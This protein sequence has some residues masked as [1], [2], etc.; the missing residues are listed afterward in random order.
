MATFGQRSEDNLKTCHD[1]IQRLFRAVVLRRDCS[2]ICGHRDEAAQTL[3]YSQGNSEAQ[4]DESMHNSFPSEAG[5]LIPYPEGFGNPH[6]PAS[7]ERSQKA[8]KELA[9]IVFD[10]A[11]KLGI[12][13][14]WGG[15]FR[16]MY[17]NET[18][19]DGDKPHWELR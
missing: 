12:R 16:S 9:E 2:V 15:L 3:A 8:F 5:D 11:I 18:I 13:V 17:N 14:K 1:D 10:E 6:D 7:M 4:W 19:L